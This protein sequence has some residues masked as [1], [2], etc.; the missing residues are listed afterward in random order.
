MALIIKPLQLTGMGTASE[1]VIAD[2]TVIAQP[3]LNRKM[4]FCGKDF[5]KPSDITSSIR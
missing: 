2:S 5:Q 1:T 3:F 4:H